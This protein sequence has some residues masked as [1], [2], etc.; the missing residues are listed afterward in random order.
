MGLGLC[1][2]LGSHGFI[3]RIL[4]DMIVE[5]ELDDP[6]LKFTQQCKA[7][8]TESFGETVS[9]APLFPCAGAIA[10]LLR[11]GGGCAGRFQRILDRAKQLESAAEGT[12][13][14]PLVPHEAF[15][16]GMLLLHGASAKVRSL[17]PAAIRQ[18]FQDHGVALSAYNDGTIRLSAPSGAL[19]SEDL[20]H[21]NSALHECA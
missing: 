2:R 3:Q 7:G 13:W 17:S 8:E 18:R 10:G 16:S 12:H 15:R 5:G 19:T 14:Q 20:A 6:L 11:E 1:P 4:A 21:L 9:L